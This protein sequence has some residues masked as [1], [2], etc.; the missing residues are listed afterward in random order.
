MQTAGFKSLTASGFGTFGGTASIIGT[1]TITDVGVDVAPIRADGRYT[2]G[3]LTADPPFAVTGL[4]PTTFV[5][6]LRQAMDVGELRS[7]PPVTLSG[8]LTGAWTV[9]EIEADPPFDAEA[10]FEPWT[11]AGIRED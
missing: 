8:V 10:F 1:R 9:G 6:E 4:A 11:V 7:E 5:G 2:L 3:E